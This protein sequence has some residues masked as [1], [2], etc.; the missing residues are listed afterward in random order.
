MQH[1][2]DGRIGHLRMTENTGILNGTQGTIISNLV[3]IL[4][5]S[6]FCFEHVQIDAHTS[7]VLNLSCCRRFTQQADFQQYNVGRV[8]MYLVLSALFMVKRKVTLALHH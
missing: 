3:N 8:D 1:P 5:L 4:G 6:G 2:L 7:W